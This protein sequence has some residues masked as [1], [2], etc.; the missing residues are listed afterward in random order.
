MTPGLASARGAGSMIPDMP[1]KAPALPPAVV[2]S[3]LGNFVTNVYKGTANRRRIG[4]GTT[5]DAVRNEL[6]TGRPSGKVFHSVKAQETIDGLQN[7][8]RLN[9]TAA[10]A[11]RD[12]AK[13][14]I[15]ELRNALG[16]K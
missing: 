8:L 2:N 11:D 16:G 3:K 12:V 1:Q 6:V 9:P 14:L 13:E 7:W 4:D 10:P 15:Q 5:M